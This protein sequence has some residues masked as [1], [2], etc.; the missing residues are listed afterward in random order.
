MKSKKACIINK[1]LVKVRMKRVK[2]NYG[3]GLL[4]N[5]ISKALKILL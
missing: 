3:I 5:R 1:V 2:S 4:C